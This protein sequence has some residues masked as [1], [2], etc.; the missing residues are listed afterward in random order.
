MK[1]II[2]LIALIFLIVTS[3]SAQKVN[4]TLNNARIESGNF[5][6]D[7]YANV[8]SGQSWS[9]GPT[10]IR[11]RFWTENPSNGITLITESPVTNAN[12]N[13][14]NNASY[15]SMSSTSILSDTVVSLNIQ[16]LLSG[17]AQTFTTGSYWLGTLKFLQVDPNACIMMKFMETSAVFNGLWTSLAYGSGW[18]FTDPN[19]C[20][21]SGITHKIEEIPSDYKLSQNYPNPFNPST[22]IKFAIPK[23]GFVT[24]RVYDILGRV[25]T[26]LVN[27]YKQE[28]TYI[29]DFDA[30]S[31]T[32]GMYFYK[33][34][35]ND[36]V[37]V[38]KM[39]FVK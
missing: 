27:Q 8:L 1:K 3:L 31:L 35:V 23:S 29:V 33:L 22:S 2:S 4:F 37:A 38:K 6:I 20:L 18:T 7:V 39:V 9:V 28:G 12:V 26:E 21:T 13:I 5:L 19:P 30:S 16:L 10:N 11:I 24:L 15:Y 17:T 14:S 36:F 32:S 34:E 25:I